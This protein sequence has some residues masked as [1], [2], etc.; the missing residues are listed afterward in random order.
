MNFPAK[1]PLGAEHHAIDIT[2]TIRSLWKQ[3]GVVLLFAALSTS[4]AVAYVL[5]AQPQYKVQSDIRPVASA[6][7]DMLNESGL[8]HIKPEEA[9]RRIGS[10]MESYDV[11]LKF[12]KTNPE[13]L[14][15][16]QAPG[17]SLEET[18][19]KFNSKAFT[20]EQID[21]KK[22]ASLSEAIQLGVEYPAGVDG[23]AIVNNFTD[24]VVKSEKEKVALDLQTLIANRTEQAERKLVSK[25]AAYD[26]EKDSRIAEL[27]EKDQLKKETLQDELK[28]LRQQLQSRRQNRI[29]QL[30]EA[31]AIAKKLGI[32]TPTTP[33]ALGESGQDRQGNM[34]RTEVSN[35]QIPLYFMGQSALEAERAT[36]VSR[37]SD[38][39]TESRVDEIQKELSLLVNNRQVALLRQ[40]SNEELFL[41]GLSEIR[42]ELAHLKGLNINIDQFNLVNIDKI[43]S[44][45]QSPIKPKKALIVG[46]GLIFGLFLG[47]ALA[48]VRINSH[49]KLKAES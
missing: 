9:L 26:A 38:D 15:P 46:F 48:V 45:P 34:I 3:R 13:L 8:Y 42:E 37:N 5:L 2:E 11:R 21:P 7:L 27:L 29:K 32:V 39:F 19:E 25:K 43:A 17:Q 12:F 14:A 10:S 31:I 23:V 20:V 28:A 24:F 4:A 33:S 41:K 40:R 30:D 47:I 22:T 1:I 36:L 44:K 49:P 16:L 18:F 35:Q 6:D